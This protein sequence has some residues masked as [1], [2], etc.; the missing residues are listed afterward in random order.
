MKKVLLISQRHS[1]FT[2]PITRAFHRLGWEVQFADY[3]GTAL[4]MTNTLPQRIFDKLPGI[5]REPLHRRELRKV[6]H[7]IIK[8]ARKFQPDLVFVSKGKTLGLDML[9]ELRRHSVVVNWY[10]ETMDHLQRMI[11]IAPHYS[12]FFNFDPM[13]VAKLTDSGYQHAHYLPFCAD[14]LR[15]ASFPREQYEYPV[16]FIGSY[17]RVRYADREHI[18]ARVKDVGLHVW[19]NKAWKETSLNDV[20]H[21][22]PSN[23]ERQNIYARSKVVISMHVSDVLGT[24]ANVRPFEITG[25]GGFLLNRDDKKEI[26][27][28]FKEGEEFIPFHNEDDIR[29][30]VEY[31]LAHD[32]ERM[33]IARAGFERT[34]SSHTYLDRISD[35]LRITGINS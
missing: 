18:L 32:D 3:L 21:G 29:A 5:V 10:P 34:R 19:G 27:N 31:Y 20:Y 16:S 22:Y 14:I 25:A 35:V 12:Y 1:V 9:D 15:D 6:D 13:V 17:D 23:E 26:F 8:L 24:G 2:E 4:L 30:K 28:L 33:R 7:H 11:Q